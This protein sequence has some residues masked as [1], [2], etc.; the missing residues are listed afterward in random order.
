[1]PDAKR[2]PAPRR[3]Y[4]IFYDERGT[5]DGPSDRAW[6]LVSAE[7]DGEARDDIRDGAYGGV[8]CFSYRVK[9][10]DPELLVD[11]RFEWNWWPDT[12]FSDEN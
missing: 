1:M 9:K 4:L 8:Y 11:E 2:A 6:V 7:G 12:G 5:P 10:G 3:V